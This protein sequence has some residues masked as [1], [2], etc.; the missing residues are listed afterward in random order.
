MCVCVF[1]CVCACVRACVCGGWWQQLEKRYW[2]TQMTK[3]LMVMRDIY[4]YLHMF[5]QPIYSTPSL[6]RHIYTDS[7]CNI[8]FYDHLRTFHW[9]HLTSCEIHMVW[10][11]TLESKPFDSSQRR[12]W[13]CIVIK[14][15]YIYIYIYNCVSWGNKMKCYKHSWTSYRLQR[16]VMGIINLKFKNH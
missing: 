13:A 4:R 6:I 15:S 10:K 3:F 2:A 11:S 12:Q 5:I 1:V 8:R 16:P 9:H 7:S 14:F